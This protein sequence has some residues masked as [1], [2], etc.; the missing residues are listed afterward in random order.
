MSWSKDKQSRRDVWKAWDTCY[1]TSF[2]IASL[3]KD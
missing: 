1:F 3:G 2:G